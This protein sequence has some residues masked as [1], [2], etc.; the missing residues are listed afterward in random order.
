MLLIIILVTKLV[1]KLTKTIILRRLVAKDM[2]S[3]SLN[4][5]IQL[6]KYF[7]YVIAITIGLE[8]MGIKLSF[9]LASSAALLVGIG[10]GLQ[11]LFYDLASGVILL[12]EGT[13][14]VGDVVD[15]KNVVGRVTDI[16]IRTSKIKT[17]EDVY[18]IVPNSKF[19]S[20]DVVN[21]SHISAATRFNVQVG[22]AYGSD[23]QLVKK[24]LLNAADG[25]AKIE[26]TPDPFVRFND[27]GDSSLVFNLYFWT[28]ETFM[29][30]NIKSDLRFS[31]DELFRKNGIT[32][33]FPQRDLHIKSGTL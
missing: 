25:H 14:R 2:N 3:G 30:E 17:R 21:W 33:P 19:V 1:I 13:I 28:T 31:I 22:V 15:L 12:F 26:N 27:F 18:V 32:I 24:L 20:G 9:L 23:V 29:V 10:L 11:Q 4:S 7:L 6:I 8:S 16:G 5:L